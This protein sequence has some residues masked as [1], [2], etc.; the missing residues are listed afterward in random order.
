MVIRIDV[1]GETAFMRIPFGPNSRASPFVI[2]DS[3]AFAE[4]YAIAPMPPPKRA[5]TDV[6]F[7]TQPRP[8]CTIDGRRAFVVRNALDTQREGF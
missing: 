6:M 2:V 4:E 1:P 7:T 5:A 8:R 3:V